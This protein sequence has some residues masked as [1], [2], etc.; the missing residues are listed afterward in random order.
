MIVIKANNSLSFATEVLLN[1]PT[2]NHNVQFVPNIY[3]DMCI[4]NEIDTIQIP[5]DRKDDMA[6]ISV[7]THFGTYSHEIK[8]SDFVAATVCGN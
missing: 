3:S 1:C 2:L 5:P 8:L 7:S 4:R 6:V